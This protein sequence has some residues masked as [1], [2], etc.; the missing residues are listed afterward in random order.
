VSLMPL[1]FGSYSRSDS[2]SIIS[3]VNLSRS[4]ASVSDQLKHFGFGGFVSLIADGFEKTEENIMQTQGSGVLWNLYVR[5]KFL[6][7]V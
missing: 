4:C 1:F 2:S 6:I 5:L 3:E 7:I